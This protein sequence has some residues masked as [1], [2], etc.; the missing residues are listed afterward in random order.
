MKSIIFLLFFATCMKAQSNIE[1]NFYLLPLPTGICAKLYQS[2]N[3]KQANIDSYQVTINTK[4]S[5][6]LYM[7]SNELQI[8]TPVKIENVKDFLFDIGDIDVNKVENYKSF[9]K[10]YFKYKNNNTIDC[11][12]Y[13]MTTNNILNRFLLMYPGINAQNKFDLVVNSIIEGV[14]YK[15]KNW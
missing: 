11:V 15:K 4:P 5:Y 12:I 9:I 8:P 10:V 2:T 1:N 7:M 13:M 6:I 14:I 3:E